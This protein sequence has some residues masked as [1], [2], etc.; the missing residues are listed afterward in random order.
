MYDQKGTKTNQKQ[1]K[2]TNY[3]CIEKPEIKGG[4]RKVH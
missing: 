3:K 2:N 1:K 4:F